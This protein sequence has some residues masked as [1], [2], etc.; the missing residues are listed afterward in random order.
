[1]TK[2]ICMIGTQFLGVPANNGG[3]IEYLSF[4]IAK[5]LS[6]KG[7]EITYFSVDQSIKS[8]QNFV[9]ERFPSKKT[10]GFFFSLFVLFKT[11][12]KK[13]DLIY[14]SGCSMI[15]AGLI[16]SKLKRIPLVYHEFNHNPWVKPRNKF[17]DFLAAFSVKNSDYVIAS[18][19]FI[20]ESILI[21]TGVNPAKLFLVSNFINLKEFP[22]NPAK[23][24]RKILFVGRLVKHKG[25][26]LLI[27]L[28]EQK[29]FREWVFEFGCPEPFSSE[30]KKYFKKISLLAE[31]NKRIL[32]KPNLSRKDLIREFS[33]ASVL[34]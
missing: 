13:S 20:K 9:I 21:K 11:L 6:D 2:K 24:E 16:L 28:A 22:L 29:E 7:F 3:A 1:M 18:S 31:S 17:Y 15:F 32:F 30:E 33:S 34:L 5:G 26:D 8:K 10:N 25:I 23:K 4:N 12:F 14:V 19:K 27:K